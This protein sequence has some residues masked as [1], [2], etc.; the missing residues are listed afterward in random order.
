LRYII[1]LAGLNLCGL[2]TYFTLLAGLGTNPWTVFHAGLS[3]YLPLTI[4]QVSQVLG[5]FIIILSYPLGV[6]ARIGTFL[7]MFFFGFFYDV[8]A[9]LGL[10]PEPTSLPAQFLYLLA[11]VAV[12]GAGLGLY[13]SV[14]LGAGP[15]DGLTLGLHQRLGLSIRLV[16]SCIELAAL[17]CGYLIGGPVGIGTLFY[18]LAIG[19]ALQYSLQLCNRYISPLFMPEQK[20]TISTGGSTI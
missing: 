10:F 11:G 20:E 19:P 15:R 16:R 2:G 13:V 4:G 12:L 6:R 5:I 18:A 17:F 7:N 9:E 8:W 14:G 1:I 3:H